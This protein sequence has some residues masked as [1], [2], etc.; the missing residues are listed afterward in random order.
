MLDRKANL[1]K[2]GPNHALEA[3][4]LALVRE[5]A[6]PHPILR[7]RKSAEGAKADFAIYANG[8]AATAIGVQLKTTKRIKRFKHSKAEFVQF[9]NTSGYDGLLLLLIAFVGSHPR[10]WLLPGAKYSDCANLSI[11][12]YPGKQGR[13]WTHFEV[14]PD[15]IAHHL[16]CALMATGYDVRPADELVLPHSK[17]QLAEYR[18]FQ[19]LQ[20]RLPFELEDAPVDH[21][22]Y[23]RIVEGQ[24]WQLKLA[25]YIA[26]ADMFQ[27]ILS[28]QGGHVDGKPTPR[29]YEAGDFDWLCLQLPEDHEKLRGMECTFL[30]PMWALMKKGLAG[31]EEVKGSAIRLF[32]HRGLTGRGFTG[33]PHWTQRWLVDLSSHASALAG[34]RRVRR[35]EEA[36][37]GGV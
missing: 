3:Q 26:G 17:T 5:S 34:Y 11:S 32:P 30:I 33:Q 22:P 13:D 23:D 24:K 18:A 31:R 6:D 15:A 12:L 25:C 8:F 2:Y 27:T 9:A 19:R 37:G 4:G 28:K 36:D 20:R 21:L 16:F 14:A 35:Q 1:A 7:V 29:Q 10:A